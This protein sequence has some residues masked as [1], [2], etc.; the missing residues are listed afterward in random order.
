MTIKS[1][2]ALFLEGVSDSSVGLL[3]HASIFGTSLTSSLYCLGRRW[4]V[5]P[6][7]VRFHRPV[8]TV[9]QATYSTDIFHRHCRSENLLNI[10]ESSSGK[11]VTGLWNLPNIFENRSG[12]PS[13]KLKQEWY[14]CQQSLGKSAWIYMGQFGQFG[15]NGF[16]WGQTHFSRLSIS[17]DPNLRKICINVWGAFWDTYSDQSPYI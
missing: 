15:L 13:H 5:P 1:A 11:T 4:K 6:I 10:V 17:L 9:I 16:K 14:T 7:F 3:I 8:L 2:T 12:K